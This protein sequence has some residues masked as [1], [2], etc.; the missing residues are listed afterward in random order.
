MEVSEVRVG[1]PVVVACGVGVGRPGRPGRRRG[2]VTGRSGG[3][4]VVAFPSG[5][6]TA[7]FTAREMEPAGVVDRLADLVNP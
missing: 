3:F 5:L 2:L 1:L 4:W 7:L 6:F